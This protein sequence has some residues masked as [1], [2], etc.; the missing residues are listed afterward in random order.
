M[1]SCA[2]VIVLK[3]LFANKR[4]LSFF[5][6]LLTLSKLSFGNQRFLKKEKEKKM[7]TA[8]C[9]VFLTTECQICPSTDFHNEFKTFFF[10]FGKKEDGRTNIYIRM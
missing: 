5:L 2:Y 3:S 9:D 7:A 6:H 10:F 8:Q 4:K 1:Q